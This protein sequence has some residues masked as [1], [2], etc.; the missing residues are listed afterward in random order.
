MKAVT[1]AL[2]ELAVRRNVDDE[3]RDYVAFMALALREIH[4]TIDVTCAAWEKR[5]YWLKAD[6]FRREWMWAGSAADALEKI[7][8]QDQWQ[9]MPLTMVEIS[10]HLDKVKLPKKNPLGEP[11]LGAYAALREKRGLARQYAVK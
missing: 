5:D 9:E 6:Q 4:Q 7:V 2:R 1:F 11:W 10:K 8:L 3:T